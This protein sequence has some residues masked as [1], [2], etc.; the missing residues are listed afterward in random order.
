MIGICEYL[1]QYK[2][3]KVS[4]AYWYYIIFTDHLFKIL[5]QINTNR[6]VYPRRG[7][8]MEKLKG[9][10]KKKESKNTKIISLNWNCILN[11][12]ES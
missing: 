3:L 8:I 5:T 4:I 7:K 2:Q 1:I 10:Q 11:R 12:C 6:E 9:H